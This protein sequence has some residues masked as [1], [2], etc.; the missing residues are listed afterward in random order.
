V[1]I[2]IGQNL[3]NVLIVLVM[4]VAFISVTWLTFR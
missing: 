2:E 1:Q 3:S 4:A